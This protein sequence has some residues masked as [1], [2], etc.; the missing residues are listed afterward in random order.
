M[1]T[2]GRCAG[3]EQAKSRRREGKDSKEQLFA[4]SVSP[5][6]HVSL[7]NR[8]A[9]PYARR[10]PKS[11]QDSWAKSAEQHRTVRY[12][13]AAPRSTGRSSG[14]KAAR[15]NTEEHPKDHRRVLESA[16]EHPKE[17][18]RNK[19]PPSVRLSLSLSLSGNGAPII[20]IHPKVGV[21]R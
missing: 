13:K 16:Q 10:A 8:V 11:A 15:K 17:P 3:K 7:V 4:K 6:A 19:E 18:K 14:E 21:N 9:E 2:G 5:V 20:R 12:Q 1:I